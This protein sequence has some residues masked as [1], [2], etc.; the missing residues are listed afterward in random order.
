MFQGY[1]VQKLIKINNKSKQKWFFLS[2]LLPALFFGLKM[3]GK[4]NVGRE[5][6][7][8]WWLPLELLQLDG[9]GGKTEP[10]GKVEDFFLLW[11]CMGLIAEA[12]G[13]GVGGRPNEL[14]FRTAGFGC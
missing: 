6:R 11:T 4:A 13:G 9:W 14:I 12:E 1:L 10:G 2:N 3:L 7:C 5:W 8:W